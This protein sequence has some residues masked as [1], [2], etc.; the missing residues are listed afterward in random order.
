MI[1]EPSGATMT[2]LIRVSVDSDRLLQTYAD[3][4]GLEIKDLT[5]DVEDVLESEL[6][7]WMDASGLYIM[8]LKEVEE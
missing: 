6:N 5:E 8:E 1:I 4:Q 7:G 2:Y 3:S